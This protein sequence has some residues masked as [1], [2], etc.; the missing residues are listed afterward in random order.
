MNMLLEFNY[1]LHMGTQTWKINIMLYNYVK[2]EIL[3]P[4]K[5][6]NVI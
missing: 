6:R 4:E 2:T 3:I 5:N 1:Q